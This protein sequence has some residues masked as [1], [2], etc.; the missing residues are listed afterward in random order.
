MTEADIARV[1]N[2]LGSIFEHGEGVPANIETAYFWYTLA[3]AAG[4]TRA[5]AAKM[6]LLSHLTQAA[7]ARSE[8]RATRWLSLHRAARVQAQIIP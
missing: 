8:E 2:R 5:S 7:R 6:R 3:E 4:E 1:R